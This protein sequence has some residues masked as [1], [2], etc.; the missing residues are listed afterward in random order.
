[1]LALLPTELDIVSATQLTNCQVRISVI[2]VLTAHSGASSNS[3]AFVGSLATAV[4][5]ERKEERMNN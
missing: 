3:V 4:L 1:M 2:K 5:N